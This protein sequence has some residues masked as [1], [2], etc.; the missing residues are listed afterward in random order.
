MDKRDEFFNGK[1]LGYA[2][3]EVVEKGI[4]IGFSKKDR[5]QLLWM[6]IISFFLSFIPIVI[7]Y[8]I[9]EVSSVNEFFTRHEFSYVV[10]SK[11]SWIFLFVF[12]ALFFYYLLKYLGD[13]QLTIDD[14]QRIIRSHSYFGLFKKDIQ[15]KQ[16][17]D[18]QLNFEWNSR[19]SKEHPQCR[20][21]FLYNNKQ[22]SF[23]F[24]DCHITDRKEALLLI[25]F[26]EY[27]TEKLEK[28][29]S[30][31]FNKNMTEAKISGSPAFMNVLKRL[32]LKESVPLEE[33]LIAYK[34][35][36]N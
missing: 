22:D 1:Q 10:V 23:M 27:L 15:F 13:N 9:N 3:I 32:Q 8:V 25:L 36:P 33:S 6:T 24:E 20:L 29:F 2:H 5:S 28:D 34:D 21:R 19:E 4:T 17:N 16:L 35:F 18:I 26:V 11:L 30:M 12:L 14:E 7:L 31:A